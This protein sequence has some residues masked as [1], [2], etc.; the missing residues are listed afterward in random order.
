M[1]LHRNIV[2]TILSFTP[3][4]KEVDADEFTSWYEDCSIDYENRIIEIQVCREEI[5]W[6]REGKQKFN[7]K[8]FVDVES[9]VNGFKLKGEFIDAYGS[10]IVGDELLLNN[11]DA[12]FYEQDKNETGFVNVLGFCTINGN[13]VVEFSQIVYSFLFNRFIVRDYIKHILP[14]KPNLKE[15]FGGKRAT[16]RNGSVLS[17]RTNLNVYKKVSEKYQQSRDRKDD[18]SY[19]RLQIR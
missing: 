2:D 1:S 11:Y 16:Y 3:S 5:N 14:F 4:I 8:C 10:V 19:P 17:L 12:C 9:I 6:I 7:S 18:L 13:G 15:D